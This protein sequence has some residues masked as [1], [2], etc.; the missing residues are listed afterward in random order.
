MLTKTNVFATIFSR[1]TTWLEDS[2][3]FLAV[4]RA[5]SDQVQNI[6]DNTV[7]LVTERYLSNA[8]GAQLDQWGLILGEPRVG[9]PDEAYRSAIRIRILR[10]TTNATPNRIIRI[11]V[12]LAGAENAKY[13]DLGSATFGVD[14]FGA[15]ANAETL[16]L[17]KIAIGEAKPA[18]VGFYIG[19]SS[20]TVVF[21]TDG[22]RGRTGGFAG[23]S[24]PGSGAPMASIVV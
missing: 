8:V 10:N 20:H 17:A 5:I 19:A 24:D 15:A 1:V 2:L 6:D 21:G 18:G 11:I 7:E 12:A 9:R 13:S 14:L 23:L 3:N 22:P 4:L 16:S